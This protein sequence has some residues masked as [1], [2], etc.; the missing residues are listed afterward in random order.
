M[1]DEFFSFKYQQSRVR[2]EQQMMAEKEQVD[3]KKRKQEEKMP[4]MKG[5]GLNSILYVN[6]GL[7][8]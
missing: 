5:Y 7:R 1:P 3:K 8:T 4:R 2:K 6:R